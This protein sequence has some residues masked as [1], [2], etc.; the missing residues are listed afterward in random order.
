MYTAFAAAVVWRLKLL[1]SFV[2]FPKNVDVNCF[3]D[4]KTLLMN[5][6]KC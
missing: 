4:P 5:E 1:V 2:V 6:N 3:N